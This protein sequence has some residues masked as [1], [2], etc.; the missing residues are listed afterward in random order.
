MFSLPLSFSACPTSKM[1]EELRS[2][3]FEACIYT[4]Y[5]L[6]TPLPR[7]SPPPP[8]PLRSI[9]QLSFASASLVYRQDPS[10]YPTKHTKSPYF[11]HI[12][13]L[14][15]T[16]GDFYLSLLPLSASLSLISTQSGCHSSRGSGCAAVC[17]CLQRRRERKKM[18]TSA[19]D[20]A[21]DCPPTSVSHMSQSD[22]KFPFAKA[23]GGND[24][25]IKK[26]EPETQSFIIPHP[27]L[28]PFFYSL[29]KY[30][31]ER[32]VD[33][34]TGTVIPQESGDIYQSPYKQT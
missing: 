11:I 16:V 24:K 12:I 18:E 1:K 9:R 27:S 23:P 31:T 14:S 13:I 8:H 6:F 19:E 5:T 34:A 15:I 26:C 30:Q 10:L 20:S 21:P 25:G 4:E 7:S 33:S 3:C 28:S 2:R 22:R 17:L 32:A 29:T